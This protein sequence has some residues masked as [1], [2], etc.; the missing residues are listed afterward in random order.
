[1]ARPLIDEHAESESSRVLSEIFTALDEKQF[2]CMLMSKLM[3]MER[4]SL[5]IAESI[6]AKFGIELEIAK[7]TL[8]IITQLGV[9]YAVHPIH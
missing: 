1:M 8:Q 7:K 3:M 4:Y 9:L 6:A 5:T 2:C